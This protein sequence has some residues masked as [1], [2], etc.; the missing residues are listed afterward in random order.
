MIKI[1]LRVY[2]RNITDKIIII[3]NLRLLLMLINCL[4]RGHTIY[5]PTESKGTL[6]GWN[7]ANMALVSLAL[8]V[9]LPY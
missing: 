8:L 2:Q 4:Q 5:S 6:M 1:F 9:P 7:M 3:E